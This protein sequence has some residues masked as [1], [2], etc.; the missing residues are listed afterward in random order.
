MTPEQRA[1]VEWAAGFMRDIA[2]P[3][4]QGSPERKAWEGMSDA[5][6]AAIKRIDDLEKAGQSVV[7]RW[8]DYLDDD[9]LVSPHDV[10]IDG[11]IEDMRSVLEG[12]N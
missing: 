8:D 11:T 10:G 4:A 7:R 5:F 6:K 2:T 1:S 3:H 12:R 9:N